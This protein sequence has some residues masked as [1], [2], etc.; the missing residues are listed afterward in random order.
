MRHLLHLLAACAVLTAATVYGQGPDPKKELIQ[1]E[2][3]SA[4]ALASNDT[5]AILARLSDD[6]KMVLTDG[7]VLTRADLESA[8]KSGKLKFNAYNSADLDVRIF[9][10]TAVVIGSG[11]S[12]GAWDGNDFTGA[13]RFTDVY[14]RRD[15]KWLC[16]S[17]HSTALSD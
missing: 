5:P 12:K 15:G 10:D 2:Q 7:Q 3:D 13:D 11:T 16:V 1:I 6:W 9:G 14:T 8:L 17:S 4:K